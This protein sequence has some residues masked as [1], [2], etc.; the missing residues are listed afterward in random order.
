MKNLE[1]DPRTGGLSYRKAYPAELRPFIPG[2]P[3]NELK[4]SLGATSLTECGALAKFRLA[5]NTHA[6]NVAMARKVASGAFDSID[7]GNIA[8][9]AATY[10]SRELGADDKAQW[11]AEVKR[12]Y[13]PR[14]D[15]EQD[16][17]DSREMLRVRDQEG[18]VALWRDWAVSFAATLGFR[19]DPTSAPFA[20]LCVKLGEG[21]IDLWLSIDARGAQYGEES[22]ERLDQKSSDTPPEP[23]RPESATR[24]PAAPGDSFEAI[25]EAILTGALNP[26]SATTQ[27]SARTALRFLRETHGPI[28]PAALTRK[29]VTEWLT[30]LAQRPFPLPHSEQLATL[31]DLAARYA[32]RPDM[33]R[34]SAKTLNNYSGQIATLWREG[35]ELGLIDGNLPDPFKGRKA[36]WVSR[37]DEPQELSRAELTTI[38]ALPVFTQGERPTQGRGEASFWLPLMLLWTGARPEELAQLIVS[39]ISQDAETGRWMLR[40]TDEGEH[41]VKGPRSLK[42]SKKH[43]GRRTFPIPN[44]LVALGF[45][46]FVAW[47]GSTG[48]T[49]LFPRLTLK[50][51]RRHLFPGW[52]EWWS[53]YLR[54]HGAFPAGPKRRAAREFRHNWATA[55]RAGGIDRETREYIQGH[56]APAAR[57]SEGERYGS[58]VSLGLAID[59]LAYPGLDLSGV[60]RWAPPP[61]L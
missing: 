57:A 60:R 43:S 6:S 17:R 19:L 7:A 50:N 12:E 49:A 61:L 59:R 47:T 56:T 32:N 46:D 18:L 41:P 9:I 10:V 37:P 42:T 36:A 33:P 39:D 40:I 52:G 22:T 53:K 51:A 55:A 14:G 1:R 4:V 31:R 5:A 20:R 11:G 58:K 34:L 24:S 3:R 27:Q 15:L 30:L 21:A 38:F 25:A 16:Y 26:R 45:L 8:Y 48:N 29:A 54:L 28:Q 35:Q 44:A 23:I 2:G 13:T